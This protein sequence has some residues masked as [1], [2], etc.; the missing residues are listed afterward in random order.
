MCFLLVARSGT[1]E[2]N[3]PIPMIVRFRLGA[4]RSGVFP[5]C[6]RPSRPDDRFFA[7]MLLVS[8][9]SLTPKLLPP[10]TVPNLKLVSGVW[11]KHFR[12]MAQP[13]GQR[14]RS[15]Q[16]ILAFAQIRVIEINGQ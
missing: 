6:V 13:L 11:R 8:P 9:Y 15:Q 2:S 7:A 14:G 10:P 12:H 5:A 3:C 1:P 16:R 4:F